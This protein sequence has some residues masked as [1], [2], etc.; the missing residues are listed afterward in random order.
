M[1]GF[2]IMIWYGKHFQKSNLQT[3][4]FNKILFM[5]IFK[6]IYIKCVM[7]M[8]FM[9]MIWYSLSKEQSAS[10]P[11]KYY[12]RCFSSSSEYRICMIWYMIMIRCV[13]SK[14]Q[15]AN[16]CLRYY[17]TKRRG[18]FDRFKR[19]FAICKYSKRK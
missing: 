4:L 12:S 10:V 3:I 5:M 9:I 14:K 16:I 15:S 11:L 17:L 1:I 19:T 6:N 2:M 7:C 13:L 8:I 18:I